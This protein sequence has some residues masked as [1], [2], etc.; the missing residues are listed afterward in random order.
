MC[1]I[2]K[3]Q[4]IEV[5]YMPRGRK[6]ETLEDYKR[7]IK[8]GFGQ[9]KGTD[10]KPWL[11]VQD[12]S[13]KGLSSKIFGIKTQREHH[14]LSQL[15]TQCFL[16]AEFGDLV[17]D[18]REQF[19]LLP[20]TLS[21]KI[22][23]TL[24]IA[25]PKVPSSKELNVMTTDL[26]LTIKTPDGI[27]YEAICVK[28]ESELSN[29]R[30]A[31]KIDLERVWWQL[32]GVSFRL[33]CGNSST[34][35]QAQ[36]IAWATDPVRHSIHFPESLEQVAL[37]YISNGNY[38]LKSIVKTISKITKL[39]ETDSLNLIKVIIAKKRIIVDLNIP[40]LKL[41]ILNVLKVSN[42]KNEVEYA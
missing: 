30:I 4:S 18:I 25:H 3:Q 42:I 31:E 7:S 13:S 11:R 17:I 16:L 33:F 19:P 38:E 2:I 28:P 22:A 40:I 8:N 36:N 6:L 32:L 23:E 24:N 14:F 21:N 9:G 1:T 27:R 10:Y 29:K 20:L 37:E 41:G 26:L 15:E 5:T 35:I 34:E 39:N 12:V